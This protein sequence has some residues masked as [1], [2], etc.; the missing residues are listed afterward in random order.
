MRNK[1]IILCVILLSAVCAYQ[2]IYYINNIR[3][4]AQFKEL[5]PFKKRLPVYFRGYKIG[6]TGKM[7]PSKD[8]ASTNIEIILNKHNLILPDNSSV[9]I[10]TKDKKDYIEFIYPSSP[11]LKLLK[12]NAVIEGEKGVNIYSY[13]N[14]QAES[15][16]LDEIKE[17]IN[18]TVQ[19]AGLTFDALTELTNTANLI[20]N[21]I[22]PSLVESSNNLAVATKNLA[23]IT[24]ELNNTIQPNKLDNIISNIEDSSNNIKFATSNISNITANVDSQII[25][26]INCI[27][28]NVNKFVLNL[29]DIAQGLKASL[30][31]TFAGI[32][33]AF[34]K[35]LK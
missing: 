27:L 4:I 18:S 2:F 10:R 25:S 20:L 15:G 7:Y 11:S 19:S 12:N 24:E 14:S 28:K 16:G 35:P 3:V 21:D 29:N 31:K 5:E 8:Y 30:S 1:L 9:K 6:Y 32:R 34:G 33:L 13:I 22:R 17:N 26:M 23:S